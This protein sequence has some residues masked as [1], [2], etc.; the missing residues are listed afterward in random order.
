MVCFY[1]CGCVC[2]KYLQTYKYKICFTHSEILVPLLSESRILICSSSCIWLRKIPMEIHGLFPLLL[3]LIFSDL[4]IFQQTIVGSCCIYGIQSTFTYSWKGPSI[5]CYWELSSFCGGSAKGRAPSCWCMTFK[6]FQFPK[7][8]DSILLWMPSNNRCWW[9]YNLPFDYSSNW[10]MQISF[11]PLVQCLDVDN[12]IKLFTAVLLE[13]RI[14]LR[15]NKYASKTLIWV[16]R[17]CTC[18]HFLIG[19]I[20]WSLTSYM[21][22]VC[23][24]NF[25]TLHCTS[26]W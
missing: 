19:K 1:I 20:V 16:L 24:F 6:S 5:V 22:C 2:I 12:L 25:I 7:L 18:M 3:H 10:L 9:E 4:Q 21:N 17:L 13:R 11:Q 8:C 23:I 14:L 26:G 15:S